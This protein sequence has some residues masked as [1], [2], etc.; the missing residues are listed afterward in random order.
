[1]LEHTI[2][3]NF[4]LLKIEVNL[5]LFDTHTHNAKSQFL[6][7]KQLELESEIPKYF[8]SL[9]IH[10]KDSSLFE[11]RKEEL[12]EILIAKCS[13]KNC[14]AIGEIGLDNRYENTKIQEEV[15]VQQLQIAQQLQKPII[16]HSV[17]SIDR[18]LI[19][20]KKY[21]P[22]CPIIYHGFNKTSALNRII[23]H[24]N[25]FFS[26]GESILSNSVLQE[27]VKSIPNHR[28]FLETDTSLVELNSLYEEIA[29]IKSIPLHQF[30]DEIFEN[31]KRVFKL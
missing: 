28:L 23:H 8:F 14:L 1:M 31:A 4:I 10:P 18:I 22:S 3:V 9:G 15:F 25:L 21:S 6:G 11:N 2:F 17:N 20:H 16:L 19:L 29:K 12:K 27:A 30:I 26:I 5:Y 13:L 7:I 24:E